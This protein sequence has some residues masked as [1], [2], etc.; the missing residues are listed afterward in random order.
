[1]RRRAAG[2]FGTK[3]RTFMTTNKR[4]LPKAKDAKDVAKRR[5][6][7]IAKKENARLEKWEVE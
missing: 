1:M 4:D 5:A 7:E 2:L 3:W 6:T